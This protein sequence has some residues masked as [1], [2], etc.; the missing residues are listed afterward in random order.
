[1]SYARLW[2]AEIERK[3]NEKY[4][5]Y[6]IISSDSGFKLCKVAESELKNVTAVWGK[7]PLTTQK[8]ICRVCRRRA[9]EHYAREDRREPILLESK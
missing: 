4:K 6:Y 3:S 5:H 2:L 7:S 1:M 9:I 8:T